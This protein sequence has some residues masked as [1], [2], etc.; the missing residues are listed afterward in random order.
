ARFVDPVSRETSGE[1]NVR[2]DRVVVAG[3]GVG[4]PML[5]LRSGLANGS[6]MV[7]KNFFINPG[8]LTFGLFDREL[9]NHRGIPNAYTVTEFREARR[10]GGRYVEGGYLMLSSHL[11]PS[12]TSAVLAGFG[13]DLGRQMGLYHR[14][15]SQYSVL[16]DEEPG[17]VRMGADGRARVHYRLR[18]DDVLKARDFLK[19]SA[20]ILLAAGAKEVWV[21]NNR[22][23]VVRDE[24]EIARID[25]IDFAPNT[26]LSGGP[27]LL[28]T[29]RMGADPETSVV[30]AR[31]ES[32]E[33]KGLYVVDGSAIPTSMSVDPS[34]TIAA[35][36]D[37]VGRRMIA[38]A[39]A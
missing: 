7:G 25:E 27:H 10:D 13:E 6:G 24:D 12:L 36:S 39:R 4:S 21:P 32:H 17:E 2:S 14:L 3:G 8:Y 34:L 18:G 31:C 20:R 19:K 28:G 5:L 30:D 38:E 23:T 26:I 15:A 35:L 11:Y 33:V 29:C 1:L 9:N 16:D 37:K 22:R